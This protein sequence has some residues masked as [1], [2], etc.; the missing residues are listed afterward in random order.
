M[1]NFVGRGRVSRLAAI[2]ALAALIALG[3]G[4]CGHGI[5]SGSSSS[6][7]SG[8]GGSG[9]ARSVYVT[10]F[11]DGKLSALNNS[12]GTL[13]SPATIAAGAVNGPLGLALTPPG[14]FAPVALY[15]ANPADN[16]IHQFTVTSTGNLSALATIAAGTQ[17]QQ[18]AVTPSGSFAYAI[19]LGASISEYLINSASGQLSVNAPSSIVT[20]LTT[21]VSGVAS[22]S[23]LYVTDPS[24]GLGLVLTFTIASGGVLSF[25]SGAATGGSNPGQ[26]AI[27]SV[28]GGSTWVFVAD[29][30]SG[31]VS[32]F[33]VVGSALSLVTTIPTGGAAAGM[34][35][36]T[37]SGGTFLYVANP[38]QDLVTTFSFNTATGV[39]ALFA[40]TA[41]FSTPTG[42]AVDNPSSATT[43]FVT[44]NGA[45]TVTT[46]TIASTGALTAINSFST[47]NPANGGSGPEYIAVTP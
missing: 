6:S 3:A 45:G 34:A 47:E 46:L 19:N 13:S 31:L 42:L 7:S 24:G 25:T 22:D 32:V 35:L 5:F 9:T 29:A 23:F 8:G 36:A 43:L 37:T 38:S 15:V 21:P 17:P 30:S 18:I 39:L 1:S 27:D 10:N 2:A 20:G 28:S 26:I 44:N 14:S 40:T 4:A 33:Q 12:S 11:A 41:G 16:T